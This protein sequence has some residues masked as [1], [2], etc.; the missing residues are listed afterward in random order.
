M[1]IDKIHEARAAKWFNDAWKDPRYIKRL[2]KNANSKAFP[3]I[4]RSPCRCGAPVKPTDTRYDGKT[5]FRCTKCGSRK[6]R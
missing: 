3:E 6:L 2:V 4:N 1:T 5:L